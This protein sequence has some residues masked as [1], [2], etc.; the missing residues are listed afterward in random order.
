MLTIEFCGGHPHGAGLVRRWQNLKCLE[1]DAGRRKAA[2]AIL[3]CDHN[4]HHAGFA[5]QKK[6]RICSPKSIEFPDLHP[7]TRCRP[8]LRTLRKECETF[9]KQGQR[10]D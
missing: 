4:T 9:L 10:V 2:R 5:S 3:S 7:W 8:D 6:S 1:Y